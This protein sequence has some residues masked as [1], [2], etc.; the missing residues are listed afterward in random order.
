ME[1]GQEAAVAVE[2]L[3]GECEEQFEL[4]DDGSPCVAVD[5]CAQDVPSTFGVVG[6]VRRAAKSCRTG[7]VV[8]QPHWKGRLERS[9]AWCEGVVE[10]SI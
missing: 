3:V 7:Q 2:N 4:V 9:E 6:M 8:E 10:E 5:E 1:E